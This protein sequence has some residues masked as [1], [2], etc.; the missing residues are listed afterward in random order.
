[1]SPS[2]G[3]RRR[4]AARLEATR[5]R[6]SGGYTHRLYNCS[7]QSGLICMARAHACSLPMLGT[8][9]GD[10]EERGGI[11]IEA[12]RASV[13]YGGLRQSCR[14]ADRPDRS[15]GSFLAA[16]AGSA[17]CGSAATRCSRNYPMREHPFSGLRSPSC[18]QLVRGSTVCDDGPVDTGVP[19]GMNAI[20]R[21]TQTA[22]AAEGDP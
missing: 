8:G 10:D 16:S 21:T 19:C 2:W 9:T 13:H 12:S 15:D 20:Y 1:V 4:V 3:C 17:A 6:Y 18:A 11:R 22:V 5:L 7:V 14:S